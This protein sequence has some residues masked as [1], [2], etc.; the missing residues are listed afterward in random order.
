MAPRI[1]TEEEVL[2]YFNTLSN[3]GRWG[4]DDLL[5]HSVEAEFVR[6]GSGRIV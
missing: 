5:G 6:C 2:E 3:W 1:P 4:E